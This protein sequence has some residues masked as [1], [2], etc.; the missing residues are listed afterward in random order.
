M[1][2]E[3]PIDRLRNSMREAVDYVMI[4]GQRILVLRYGDPVAALVSARDLRN[5]E[6]MDR[7][8][9]ERAGDPFEPSRPERGWG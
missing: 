4:E 3:L 9:D 8:G 6:A 5:L 7:D 2:I 1:Y